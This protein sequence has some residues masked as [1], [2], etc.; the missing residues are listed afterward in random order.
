MARF[1]RL[2]K[3]ASVPLLTIGL[4]ACSA[5]G[6]MT[7]QSVQPAEPTKV[8]EPDCA[9]LKTEID[10]LHAA[11]LPEKL[12]QAAAKKYSPT[13][14]EWASFP[15]Y[16]NL[17]ETYSVKKCQPVL[18]QATKPAP[19]AKPKVAPAKTAAATPAPAKPKP[20]A[21]AAAAPA[22]PVAAAPAETAPAAA[23]QAQPAQ[24]GYQ[25]VTIQIPPSAQPKQ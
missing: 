9:S 16:N 13:Q 23:A 6:E 21:T 15:R 11:K 17:V 10:K 5:T 8:A 22:Q 20:V 4:I 25:G 3:L 2:A 19:A 18:Q 1:E 14:D 24:P 12:Q 7:T